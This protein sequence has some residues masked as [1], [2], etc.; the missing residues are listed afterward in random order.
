[1]RRGL[2][3]L[4]LLLCA[5]TAH[6]ESCSRSLEYIL[7]GS[8][9]DLPQGP[10]SYRG[11]LKVCLGALELSN[12]K[13]A[14][15][16]KDGGIAVLPKDFSVVATASI[17]AKF[18]EANPRKTLRFLNK[19]EARSGLTTGLVVSLSSGGQASCQ[20]LRGEQ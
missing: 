19:K 3:A 9:G 17:L 12:V 13:D 10:D 11:L 5:G 1:M 20:E 18:C 15:V 7:D 6:A 2:V 8:A 4:C 16:L 14:Y